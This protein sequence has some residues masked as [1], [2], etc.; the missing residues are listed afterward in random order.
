LKYIIIL[1]SAVRSPSICWQAPVTM[2]ANVV[3]I[4]SP[5]LD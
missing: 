1:T 3:S 5:T 2:I 4:A